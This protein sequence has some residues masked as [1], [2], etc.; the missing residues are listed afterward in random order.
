MPDS[1]R[2]LRRPQQISHGNDVCLLVDGA[3]GYAAMHK[4]IADARDT[5]NLET[6]IFAS[7][8]TGWSFARALAAA[9]ERGVEVNVL[10]D[11]YGSVGC[12]T[13]LLEYLAWA[14][15]R[16]SWFKPLAPWR[17]GWGWWRRDH[18]KILVVDGSVGFVGGAEHRGRLRR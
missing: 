8:E 17:A 2:Y 18:K 13:S 6:Y 14:G 4:A 16:V 9:A 5:V 10:L 3:Q 1:N 12:A 11:G 7:D 15:V